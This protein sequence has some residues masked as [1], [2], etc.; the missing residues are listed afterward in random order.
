MP[1]G[2]GSSRKSSGVGRFEGQ[3]PWN[4][5]SIPDIHSSH[6]F[7]PVTLTLRHDR[8]KSRSWRHFLSAA[9]QLS[10]TVKGASRCV[11]GTRNRKRL[12][13]GDGAHSVTDDW[14]AL[15]DGA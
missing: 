3:A 11:S 15:L 5:P 2:H 1:L 6:G 12:P 7:F 10:T 9:C 8:A 4:P 14:F 13:S